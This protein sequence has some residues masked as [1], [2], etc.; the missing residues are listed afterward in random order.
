MRPVRRRG[1]PCILPKCGKP[2]AVEVA[3]RIRKEM[4]RQIF[5]FKKSKVRITVSIGV[6][7]QVGKGKDYRNLI[8]KADVALYRAK[9]LGRNKV[10]AA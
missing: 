1:V 8:I 4:E 2:E 10:V 6:A 9:Q 5:Y 3:E 7:T